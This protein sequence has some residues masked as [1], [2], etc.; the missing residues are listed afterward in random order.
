MYEERRARAEQSWRQELR[1]FLDSATWTP[2]ATETE[3]MTAFADAEV[4]R[5]LDALIEQVQA[6]DVAVTLPHWNK[7]ERW[8]SREDVLALLR[9]ARKG[10]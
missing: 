5:V 8:I 2:P 3:L 10:D 1:R 9:A 4:A 7:D 6:L